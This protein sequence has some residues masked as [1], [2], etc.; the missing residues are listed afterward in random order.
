MY[1]YNAVTRSVSCL[2]PGFAKR[3]RKQSARDALARCAL[4]RAHRLK[5][6][7]QHVIHTIAKSNVSGNMDIQKPPRVLC[8]RHEQVDQ[9]QPGFVCQLASSN[10]P[11]RKRKSTFLGLA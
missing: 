3:R 9:E 7:E 6:P 4:G 10:T 11:T 5:G 1:I 8:W 2:P